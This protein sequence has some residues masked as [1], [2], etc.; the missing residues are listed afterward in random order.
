MIGI[1]SIPRSMH[2]SMLITCQVRLQVATI[3]GFAYLNTS[4]ECRSHPYSHVPLTSISILFSARLFQATGTTLGYLATSISYICAVWSST[5]LCI[6]GKPWRATFSTIV[7]IGAS[8]LYLSGRTLLN[9]SVGWVWLRHVWDG[10]HV[11]LNTP[12]FWH[13]PGGGHDLEERIQWLH[14][15]FLVIG[16]I[17]GKGGYESPTPQTDS[18]HSAVP[19]DTEPPL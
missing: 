15:D 4:W 12:W 6:L 11:I 9:S 19:M 7:N 2:N 3:V 8:E 18:P 16:R 1:S 13:F 10:A 17:K 5:N 14:F